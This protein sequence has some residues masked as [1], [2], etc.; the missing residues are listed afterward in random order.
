LVGALVGA[1]ST[2]V[3]RE[4]TQ[5]KR[6]TREMLGLLRMLYVEIETNRGETELLLFAPNP[7]VGRPP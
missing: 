1:V 4:H 2:H 3:L 5:N 7:K 6:E